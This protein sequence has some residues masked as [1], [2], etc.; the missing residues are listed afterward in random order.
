MIVQKSRLVIDDDQARIVAT[1]RS[2][3]EHFVPFEI[4]IGVPRAYVG[5]LDLSSSPFV[6]TLLLMASTLGERLR[7]DG[8]VSPRLLRNA[9]KASEL[10]RS[11]W[12]MAPVAVEAEA[13]ASDRP[14]GG[15][16]A[17]FFTRG[18]DSWH[19]ALRDR[20]GQHPGPV[21]HLLYA[22]D[23]D[24]QYSPATR[25]KAL[26]LTREAAECLGLPLAPVSHNGREL[27][28]R[29]VNWELAHGGVLAGV[30]LALGG[31]FGDVLRA[32]C[33]DSGHLIPWGSRP[34]PGPPL[35]HRADDFSPR[36]R[37][38]H[39]YRQGEVHRHFGFRSLAIEGLLARGHRRQLR[40][41]REVSAYPVPR[42][43]SPAPSIV[44][45]MSS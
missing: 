13:V 27:I 12:G 11:W 32:S 17:L 7:L 29:F 41:V 37:G 42:W 10:F 26:R 3:A 18:V 9:E 31:W 44:R 30:G 36:R 20:T 40:P 43:P 15:R 38:S 19:S 1:V 23:F 34:G 5:W 25:R 14:P 22:A 24:R 2:E 45:P 39:A 6:P 28:D 21:T 8:T 35:V 16:S 4:E 33:I